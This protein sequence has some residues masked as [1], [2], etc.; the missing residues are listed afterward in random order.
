MIPPLLAHGMILVGIPASVEGLDRYGSY[1]GAVATNEP[2]EVN[3]A[4]ARYLGGRITE[5]ARRLGN[6]RE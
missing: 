3:L 2:E 6:F 5:V 1:Y 4:V